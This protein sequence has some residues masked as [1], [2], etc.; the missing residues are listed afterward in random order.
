MRNVT[1]VAAGAYFQLAKAIGAPIIPPANST[2]TELINNPDAVPFQPAVPT[3]GMEFPDDFNYQ[4]DSPNMRMQYLAIGSGGHYSVVN[5]STKRSRMDSKPYSPRQTGFFD[6]MPFVVR[7][8]DNDLDAEQRKRYR[9]RK[10]ITVNGVNKIAYFYRHID[11]SSAAITQTIVKKDKGVITSVPYKPTITDLIPPDPVVSGVSDGSYIRTLIALD[12]TFTAEEAAWLR[13]V[14]EI[15]Y[16]DANEAIV[17]EI[18]I[19]SGVD[20]TITK[21]YPLLGN[22]TPQPVA[23]SLKEAVGIQINV[24]E[25][26]YHAMTFSNGSVTEKVYIGTEDPLYGP[27]S[28]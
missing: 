25:S 3:A 28:T 13:E 8:T 15:W 22:Q 12:I 1:R 4:T 24:I 5:A 17:S 14:A 18:A 26:L 11:L 19:C 16:G 20:K 23:S 10:V 6:I 9:G 21:R 27:A 7:D 2:L